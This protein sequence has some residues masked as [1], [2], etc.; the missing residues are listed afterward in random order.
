M[1]DYRETL[2]YN[3]MIDREEHHGPLEIAIDDSGIVLRDKDKPRSTG[4]VSIDSMAFE[5]VIQVWEKYKVMRE[6]GGLKD[7]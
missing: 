4:Y 2:D 3:T 5:K 7:D 6:A 1:S